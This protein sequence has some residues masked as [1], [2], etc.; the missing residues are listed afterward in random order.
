MINYDTGIYNFFHLELALCIPITKM[1]IMN[2]TK[3]LT[4]LLIAISSFEAARWVEPRIENQ[5][6]ETRS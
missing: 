4:I 5:V 6:K 1:I 2:I 3:A